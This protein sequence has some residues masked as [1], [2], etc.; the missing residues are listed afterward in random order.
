M[1]TGLGRLYGDSRFSRKCRVRPRWRLSGGACLLEHFSK[2]AAPADVTCAAFHEWR[3]HATRGANGSW[4]G[5]FAARHF[6]EFT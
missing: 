3:K 5:M 2:L 1:E 4:I 6:L